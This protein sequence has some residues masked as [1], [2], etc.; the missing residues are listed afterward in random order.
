MTREG[1]LPSGMIADYVL[2]AGGSTRIGRGKALVEIAGRTMLLRMHELLGCVASKVTVIA[3]PEKYAS[4]GI[5]CVAD[6]WPG[7]GPLG[8]ILTALQDAGARNEKSEWSLIVSCDMP[9]LTQDWLR[10][11]ANRA[12]KSNAQ[13][14][15]PQS[16]SGPGP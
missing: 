8:G 10:F 11:L 2:A 4:L 12:A 3:A 14:V 16:R 7:E 6:R 15:F 9:F 5:K 1:K 13:V